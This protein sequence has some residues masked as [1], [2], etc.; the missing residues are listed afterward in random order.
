[1]TNCTNSYVLD[2]LKKTKKKLSNSIILLGSAN[3]P[4]KSLNRING[5]VFD[6]NAAE[7]TREN[8]LFPG[9]DELNNIE[10]YGEE[11]LNDLFISPFH[12]NVLFDPLS[13]TQANQIVYNAILEQGDIVLALSEKSGGHASHIDFLKK[14][15]SVYEYGFSDLKQDIDYDQIDRLCS[16]HHPK[17]IIAGGSAFPLEIK[18]NMLYNICNKYN[19]RLLADISHTVLY[20]QCRKHISPF[21]YADFITFTT[22]KTTRGPRGAILAYNPIY[23][24]QIQ[25]S[26]FP[27]SQG[28]P[29]FSQICAKV[30]M[31]EEMAN[32]NMPAYCNKILSLSNIFLSEIRKH[33]IPVWTN[34]TNSHICVLDMSEYYSNTQELQRVFEKNNILLN[35]CWLPQNSNNMTG[36]RIGFMF[37]A[38]L[39][40]SEN[41]FKNIIKIIIAIIK[42]PRANYRKNVIDIISPYIGRL[43]SKESI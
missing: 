12:Y 16:E 4:Y 37:L 11:I 30:L 8:R 34:K 38:T 9:C 33:D 22:H 7:G 17:L 26:T 27:L 43:Y 36:L 20:I 41:D 23:K 42:N 35:A 24:S 39:N 6:Y 15:Y 2:A 40:V 21:G 5:L 10:Q 31:L 1:M 29:I 19:C 18:Y 28:A 3:I 14:Y 25:Y 13:G 32:D